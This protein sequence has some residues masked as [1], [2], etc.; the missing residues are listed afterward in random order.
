M[1][2]YNFLGLPRMKIKMKTKMKTIMKTLISMISR[3][4]WIFDMIFTMIL[5]RNQVLVGPGRSL[6]VLGGP[7]GSQEVLG[8]RRMSQDLE[9]L[10]I[11]FARKEQ[12]LIPTLVFNGNYD[13]SKILI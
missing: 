10:Y 8:S 11:K 6:E 1:T 2:S 7:W 3:I 12:T 4:F 9:S 13:F 5:Q